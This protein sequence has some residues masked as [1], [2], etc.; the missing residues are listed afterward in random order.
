MHRIENPLFLLILVILMFVH[1]LTLKALE[2]PSAVVVQN[3]A[4]SPRLLNTPFD[5]RLPAGRAEKP[6]ELVD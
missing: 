1:I 6:D 2:L 5:A 3:S 4:Y